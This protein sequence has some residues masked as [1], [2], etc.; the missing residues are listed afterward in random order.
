MAKR[1]RSNNNQTSRL[2]SGTKL[3]LVGLALLISG[4]SLG[5]SLGCRRGLILIPTTG[6]VKLDGK[7]LADCAITFTPVGGG[8]VASA[9]TDAQGR[10]VLSTANRPGAVPGEHYVTLTKQEMRYGPDGRELAYEFLIP[11]KYARPDTSGLKER[12]DDDNHEFV[13]EISLKP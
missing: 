8:P 2:Q 7:P 4:I 13:F 1:Q 5:G 9:A 3:F 11:Q 10:F 6:E 12:V